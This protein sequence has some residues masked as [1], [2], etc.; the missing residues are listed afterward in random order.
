MTLSPGDILMTGALPDAPRVRAG[1]RIEIGIDN[2]GKL[3]THV[4]A[5]PEGRP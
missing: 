1:A 3:E 4:A 5:A 2:V